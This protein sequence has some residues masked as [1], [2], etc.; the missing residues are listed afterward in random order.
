MTREVAHRRS[1]DPRSWPIAVKVPLIVSLLVL[2]VSALVTDRVLRRLEVSQEEHLRQLAGAY[3]DGLAAL[4]SPHVLHH[5]I[6][7]VYDGLERAAGVYTGLNL[8][9]TTVVTPTGTVVASS[10]PSAFPSDTRIPAKI[11]EPFRRTEQLVLATD[12]ARAH[13]RRSL[14]YQGKSIGTIYADVGIERLLRERREVLATL[15][16]TNALLTLLLASL[17]YILVRW[18][19][20]PI[21]VLSQYLGRARTER[22]EP[23]PA[24]LMPSGETEFGRLFERYN[25]MAEAQRERERL[26]TKLAE[27]EKLASLGRLTSGIAHEI[28]N[29]LGGL[30]NA[31]DALKR[32]GDVESVR[33][34]SISLLERGLSGI[35]D[36]VRA[37]LLV[38]RTQKDTRVLSA[39]DIDDL[40]LLIGPELKRKRQTLEKSIEA[41][42]SWPVGAAAVRDIALNLLLNACAASPENGT[43]ALNLARRDRALCLTVRDQGPGMSE[44]HA[45]YLARRGA[46]NAPIE[47]QSGLG[48]W[49]VRR[50]ADDLGAEIA[51]LRPPRGGTEVVVSLPLGADVEMQHVA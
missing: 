30:F 50:L 36:V 5:D 31:I 9:W 25:A 49:M 42:H 33:S 11:V 48:L 26:A 32:H 29:P 35:R 47:E 6:W 23:I 16:L 21:K 43:I 17:G 40:A 19:L 14:V 10:L 44:A 12:E 37:A 15:V 45:R 28:N 38:Y 41:G 39:A 7:E 46:G 51:V 18:M 3:L 20:R 24:H 4:V 13:L 1:I 2:I 27:E 22:A 34:R 8:I